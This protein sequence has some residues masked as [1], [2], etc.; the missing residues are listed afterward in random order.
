MI[1]DNI[2]GQCF[3]VTN[4]R[5]KELCRAVRPFGCTS[6]DVREVCLDTDWPDAL[7]HQDWL[8][9]APCDMVANWIVSVAPSQQGGNQ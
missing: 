7:G 5:F 1:K 3:T 8:D 2:T 4:A 9:C 6:A